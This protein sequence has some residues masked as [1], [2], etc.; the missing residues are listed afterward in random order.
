MM[1]PQAQNIR[2]MYANMSSKQLAA[3]TQQG[4]FIQATSAK[5]QAKIVDMAKQSN[6]VTAGNAIFDAITTDMRKSL[7]HSN[8]HI[9]MLGA[10]GGFTQEAQHKQISALYLQQFE[11]VNNAK[12]VMNTKVRHFIFL[13][14]LDW[15]SQQITPFLGEEQ[16]ST[17]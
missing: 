3:Q 10:S 6:P 13:D 12:V 14:D 1:M 4:V 2:A 9:L 7:T 16:W 11:K 15:V 8:T 17:Q 5:H